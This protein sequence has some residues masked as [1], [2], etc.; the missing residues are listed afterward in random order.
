MGKKKKSK[1]AGSRTHADTF[2]GSEGRTRGRSERHRRKDAQLCAQVRDAVALVVAES[3]DPLLSGAWVMEA[4]PAPHIGHLQI[5]VAVGAE[6]DVDA[7]HAKLVAM[8]GLVRSEVAD[9]I[10]RKKTPTLSFV[11]MRRHEEER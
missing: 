4:V 1:R 11:V 5:M 10:H 2:F 8:S 3:T 9:A 6:G 7:I